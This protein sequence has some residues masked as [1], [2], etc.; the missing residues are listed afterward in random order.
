MRRPSSVRQSV[1]ATFTLA[2]LASAWWGCSTG[3]DQPS[4]TG[5]SQSA[6]SATGSTGGAGG[7]GTGG[8]DVMIDGGGGSVEEAGACTSVSA[9]A[10][11]ID[12][13]IIFLIDQ[14]GSMTGPKWIG[15]SAALK[16]FFTDPA[17]ANIG[18]GM[19]LFPN[20]KVSK[21]I[22]ADYETL[23]V[24][25]LTLPQ[26]TFA[27]T[28]SIPA[29]ATLYGTP[30]F[31]A[32]QGTLLA[33]TSYQD[34]HPSH[35]VIVILATDG[36]PNSCG[37]KSIYDIAALAKSAR[38]YNGVLTYV[39]GV[40]GSFIPNLNVIAYA[41][42]TTAAYD[43]TTDINQLSAKMAEIRKVSLGCDFAI[44][45]PPDGKDL[46]PG[47]VNV[48][49]TPKGMG[50]PATLPRADD[51]LDCGGKPGWYYDNNFTPTKIVLCPE[52]CTTVKADISAKVS[53]LFGCTSVAN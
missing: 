36:D 45:P 48:S 46:D 3:P 20:H 40:E 9:A 51:L 5:T 38:S 10:H 17:S 35:K 50:A 53:A 42:G 26:N 34:A 41:G 18:V 31:G 44:P 47:K 27:L 33:A 6:S 28:N 39:I 52:S 32:L 37:I 7:M 2:T 1:F 24:P 16:A 8:M 13:D 14:S 23:N 11:P 29:D 15:T 22:T 12:L 25:I 19:S 30:T 43:I 4:T 49:Y 21:C